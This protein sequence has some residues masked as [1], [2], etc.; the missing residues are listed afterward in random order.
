MSKNYV[1]LAIKVDNININR[2]VISVTHQI[3]SDVL[4]FNLCTWWG[5]T[6][7]FTHMLVT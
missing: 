5:S 1:L 3:T 2:V 6:C 4:S 7:W